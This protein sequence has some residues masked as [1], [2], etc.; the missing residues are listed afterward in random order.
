M[1]SRGLYYD[2]SSS[3]ASAGLMRNAIMVDLGVS[4][5]FDR[6]RTFPGAY[7]SIKAR[8]TPVA[9]NSL[10]HFNSEGEPCRFPGTSI[11]SL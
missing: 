2:R 7:N 8:S 9:R 10:D 1:L 5:S 6:K 11:G 4:A 3:P